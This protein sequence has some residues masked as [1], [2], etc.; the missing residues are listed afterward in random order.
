MARHGANLILG[1]NMDGQS[2]LTIA[3]GPAQALVDFAVSKGADRQALLD[4]AGIAPSALLDLDERLAF[5]R[6][7]A[8]MRVAK[9]LTGDAA[10]ALHFG[11]SVELSDFSVVGFVGPGSLSEALHQLNR[12]A[13]LVVEISGGAPRFAMSR[14]ADGLWLIDNRPDPNAFP[15]LT[16]S[17]FARVAATGRRLYGVSIAKTVH[18]THA[19]PGYQHEYERVFG[20]PVVFNSDN[21]AILVDAAWLHRPLVQPPRYLSCIG[22]ERAEALLQRL[23]RLK[24]IRGQAEAVLEQLLPKNLARMSVV[25]DALGMSRWTLARRLKAEG[26]TFEHMFD[27]LRRRLA[28]QCLADQNIAL[29]QIAALLGFSEPA[30]FS[31]AFKR[32]TG[33]SPRLARV[34]TRCGDASS[35]QK[36]LSG[37]GDGEPPE[38]L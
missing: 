8:L 35:S 37:V 28:L 21:N 7:M 22:A 9:S 36:T 2:Q 34:G 31:R 15:E 33:K 19:D 27:D 20:A 14:V 25:A 32:W 23:D 10:L 5:D 24:T 11:E 26:V 6:Y 30:A 4:R 1:C 3:A 16:E 17:T 38:R 18:V 12:Y 13:P 29:Q